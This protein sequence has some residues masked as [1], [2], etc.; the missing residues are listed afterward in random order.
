[1]TSVVLAVSDFLSVS[2]VRAAI[3]RKPPQGAIV[4]PTHVTLRTTAEL[5]FVLVLLCVSS[6]GFVRDGT[7][8]PHGASMNKTQNGSE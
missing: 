4:V 2:D 1:V 8:S 6:N 5:V 3:L 7:V